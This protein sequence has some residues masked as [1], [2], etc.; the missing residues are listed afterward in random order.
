MAVL[1]YRWLHETNL[2]LIKEA[3]SWYLPQRH[4]SGDSGG[5][6]LLYLLRQ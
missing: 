4:P 6:G 3:D 2:G 5:E 1:W